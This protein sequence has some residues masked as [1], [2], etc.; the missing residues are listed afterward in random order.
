MIDL[1]HRITTGMTVFPG[2]PT[3]HV[4][5]ALTL[6]RDGVAV[7]QISMGSHTA[8]HVDAP[9]HTVVG[10]RT[11][12]KVSLDELVGEALILHLADRGELHE[13]QPIDLAFLQEIL[14]KHGVTDSVPQH[15]VIHTGWD[16]F[17]NTDRYL[18]HPYLTQDA[19]IL[20]RD[21]GMKTLGL[22]TL[23]PDKTPTSAGEEDDEFL[24][25]EV[26]LGADGL[27]IENLTCLEQLGSTAT[28]GYFPL[29][30]GPIDGSPVRAVAFER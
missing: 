30:L 6:E 14:A 27:I 26:I 15:V 18:H 21:L 2:D 25:H 10:G 22:D 23:N 1:T 13:K 16:K 29:R 20:L 28:I 12:D 4:S 17:F 11:L 24:V 7:S 19:A 9:S 8:T 3:V 5:E